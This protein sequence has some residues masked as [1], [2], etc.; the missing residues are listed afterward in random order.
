MKEAQEYLSYIE[1][2]QSKGLLQNKVEK[3]ELEELQGIS[4]LK[5]IR[6]AVNYRRNR[7]TTSEIERRDP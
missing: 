3:L 5:G 6:V 4:G 7:R 2:L 1:F